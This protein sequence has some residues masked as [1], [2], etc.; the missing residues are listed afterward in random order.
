MPKDEFDPEDP[1]ELS[2]VG[3]LTHEDTTDTMAE[4]FIEEFMRMGHSAQSILALFRNEFYIGPNLVLQKR[5]EPFVRDRIGDVFARWGR[6][7]AWPA[8]KSAAAMA[9]LDPASTS[10]CAAPQPQQFA[11]DATLTSPTG[12]PIPTLIP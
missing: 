2:G 7:C 9:T 4:C 10:P 11:L 12:D 6:T 8:S 1:M 5:G 3:L